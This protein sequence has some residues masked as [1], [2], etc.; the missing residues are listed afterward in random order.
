[1]ELSFVKERTKYVATF[2]ATSDFNLHIERSEKGF[3]YVY[4]R[5]TTSGEYDS[6]Q[7]ANFSSV[8]KVIDC[9]FTALVYP[10]SIKVESEVEPTRC[11]VTFA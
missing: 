3:L 2:D 6:V 11:E 4:Q 9:D 7:G 1:M 5:T 10:K 8:D